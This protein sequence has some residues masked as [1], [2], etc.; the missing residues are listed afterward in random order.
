MKKNIK[1]RGILQKPIKFDIGSD[2]FCWTQSVSFTG[3]VRK[4]KNRNFAETE[5]ENR[6]MVLFSVLYSYILSLIN[7]Q[8]VSQCKVIVYTGL[9]DKELPDA[10]NSFFYHLNEAMVEYH[11][12]YQFSYCV[13]LRLDFI[14]Y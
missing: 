13:N 1:D 7:Q 9:R 10:S 14:T 6:N 11:K 2:L 8:N 4:P 12:N 3:I 5:I